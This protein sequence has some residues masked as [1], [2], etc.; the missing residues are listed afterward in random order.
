[1]TQHDARAYAEWRSLRD[2]RSHR[3]PTADEW[4]KAARGADGRKFPWGDHFDPTF[5]HTRESHGNSPRPASVGACPLDESPYGVRDMAGGARDWT[6]TWIR[7]DLIAVCGGSWN[8][9]DFFCRAA[10][11]YPNEP[12]T[13]LAS[14]G[15]RLVRPLDLLG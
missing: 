6:I 8:L 13:P 7:P 11:R 14:V 15:F 1:M 3:L 4:E 9:F 2:G 10:S 12:G 5:C